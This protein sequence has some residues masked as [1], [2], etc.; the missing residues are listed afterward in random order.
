MG[1]KSWAA[2]SGLFFGNTIYPDT[3]YGS[4]TAGPGDVVIAGVLDIANDTVYMPANNW[5]TLGSWTRL[6][7]GEGSHVTARFFAK[8][9]AAGESEADIY[10]DLMS[11]YSFGNN[12]QYI[13]VSYENIPFNPDIYQTAI[14]N[15]FNTDLDVLTTPTFSDGINTLAIYFVMHLGWSRSSLGKTV[16][17]STPTRPAILPNGMTLRATWRE[18]T[19]ADGVWVSTRGSEYNWNIWVLDALGTT[20]PQTRDFGPWDRPVFVVD[21]QSGNLP[22]AVFSLLAS[23]LPP[24]VIVPGGATW[25]KQRRQVRALD[26]PYFIRPGMIGADDIELVR[27]DGN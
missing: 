4:L 22:V 5:F 6:I 27:A 11:N 17:M 10:A 15:N 20:E 3:Y 12:Y 9:L 16:A 1:F 24:E 2:Y 14:G 26:L 19:H 13:A 23:N 8:Q 7:G 18:S 21:G 25:E